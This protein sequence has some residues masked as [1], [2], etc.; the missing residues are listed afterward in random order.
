MLKFS[1]FADLTSC[2]QTYETYYIKG[3]SPKAQEQVTSEMLNNVCATKK[4]PYTEHVRGR[5]IL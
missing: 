2:L 5:T 1:G 3:H 4:T